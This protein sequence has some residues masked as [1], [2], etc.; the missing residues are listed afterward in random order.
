MRFSISVSRVDIHRL[1]KAWRL[2]VLVGGRLTGQAELN[3][4]VGGEPHVLT[5]GDGKGLLNGALPV[6]LRANA[7]GFHFSL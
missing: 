4:I 2:P 1:P 7:S 5:T 6:H 3:V